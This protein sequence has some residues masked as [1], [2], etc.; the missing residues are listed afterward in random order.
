MKGVIRN[1]NCKFFMN[2]WYNRLLCAI[3]IENNHGDGVRL[4]MQIC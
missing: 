2:V 3:M 1:W 4:K